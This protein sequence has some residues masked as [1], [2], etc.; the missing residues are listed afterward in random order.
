LPNGVPFRPLAVTW[1]Y[2]L[3]FWL[4]EIWVYAPEYRILRQ[5]RRAQKGVMGETRDVTFRPLVLGQQVVV[6]LAVLAAFILRRLAMTHFRVAIFVLGL[7]VSIGGSLMRRH[8]FRMLGEDFRGAVTVRTG[9]SVVERGA[10]RFLRHPSYTAAMLLHIGFALGFTN[11][12]TLAVVALGVPP[13]FIY[14][15]RFEERV[16]LEEFGPSYAEYM[17]RTK[18]LIPGVW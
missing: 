15:I 9:Q 16:L 6:F 14:R 3:V 12:A 5:A 18:R 17:T 11:C 8:C 1:P 10:Y 4:V 7:V 13:L 2:A